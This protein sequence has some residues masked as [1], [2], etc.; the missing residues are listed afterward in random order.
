MTDL[1]LSSLLTASLLLAQPGVFGAPIA[2]LA[3]ERV[4]KEFVLASGRLNLND[5]YPVP[6]VSEGFKE[7]ILI[8]VDRL[9]EIN[10][11][12]LVLQP[13]EVFAF[14][15]NIAREFQGEKVVTQESGFRVKD[16]YK[17]VAGLPGNGVCHLAS[18]M[19]KVAR[20][21][22]LAVTAAVDHDFARIPGIEREY[23]TS[24]YFM[25]GGGRNSANQN[26]YLKNTL[27][28]PVRLDFNLGGDT[29]YFSI[30]RLN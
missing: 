4:E 26:L 24:I 20:E 7:N 28:F 13:G 2:G 15:K 9:K 5:R 12:R 10:G 11:G 3:G 23:G 29:L 22:G 8:A 14:H 30:N 1:I 25:P 27:N 19:N 6:S 16:G 17:V 21:A 18:L